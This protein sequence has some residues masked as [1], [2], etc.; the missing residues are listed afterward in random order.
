MKQIPAMILTLCLLSLISCEPHTPGTATCF[1]TSDGF[2]FERNEETL[3]LTAY[4]GKVA[5]VTI[6]SIHSGYKVVAIDRD[7]FYDKDFITN[8]IIPV[9]ITSIG[10]AA[11]NNCDGLSD[12]VIPE[13]VKILDK[14]TFSECR[15]LTSVFLPS[16]LEAIDQG[17][18]SWCRNLSSL[19]IP[20]NVSFIGDSTF[21]ECDSLTSMDIPASVNSIGH[22][23]FS[24]CDKLESLTFLGTIPP[25]INIDSFKY[26]DSGLFQKILVPRTYRDEYVTAWAAIAD[27]SGLTIEE[28]P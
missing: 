16:S 11:F 19:T 10:R 20:E 21:F 26:I 2:T 7:V 13:G 12:V 4:E 1:T 22:N 17:A 8:L 18:F 25:S 24:F 3:T 9:G 5:S 6:P 15:N 28:M 23:L 14:N 27:L